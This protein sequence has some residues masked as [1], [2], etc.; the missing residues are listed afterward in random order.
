[1]KLENASLLL[2]L[3]ISDA[4]LSGHDAT[5]LRACAKS[6]SDLLDP[7]VDMQ[8]RGQTERTHG[9]RTF[10][11]AEYGAITSLV[12]SRDFRSWR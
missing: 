4:S 5:A 2:D 3:L 8:K 1:M 7:I 12:D 9:G 6:V 10:V 11:T